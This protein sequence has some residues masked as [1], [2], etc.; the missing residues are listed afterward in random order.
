MPAV[1]KLIWR[2]GKTH[3]GLIMY[4]RLPRNL[5]VYVDWKSGKRGDTMR[6]AILEIL[7]ALNSDLKLIRIR[8]PQKY[9]VSSE[10][11]V[12]EIG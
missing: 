6:R 12:I 1:K 11:L 5:I 9:A 10:V 8:P 7:A 2:V 4:D 3:G